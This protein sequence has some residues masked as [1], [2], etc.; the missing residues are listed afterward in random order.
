MHAAA[1]AGVSAVQQRDQVKL[2][3]AYTQQRRDLLGSGALLL[4][5]A[6]ATEAATGSWRD[7]FSTPTATCSLQAQLGGV[8][9][10]IA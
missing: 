7:F 5:R 8:V 1:S 10:C 6:A 4:A 9:A 3:T 2:T